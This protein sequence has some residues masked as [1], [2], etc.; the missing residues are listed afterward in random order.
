VSIDILTALHNAN[1]T[2]GPGRC[3]LAK[4]LDSIPEDTPGKTDLLAAIDDAEGFPANRLTLT[5]TA[6]GNSIGVDTIRDHRADRCAC[7]R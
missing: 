5:F 3:K 2:R 1:P 4:F 7:F 6:L